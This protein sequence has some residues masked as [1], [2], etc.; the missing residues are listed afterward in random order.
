M[1]EPT[2]ALLMVARDW[3]QRRELVTPWVF[4]PGSLKRA[5][6]HTD[7]YTPQSLWAAL[8]R[9]EKRAGIEHHP[10]RASHELR[11]LLAGEV[12]ELTGNAKLAMDAI[13]DRDIRQAQRYLRPRQDALK[14][15]FDR[16]DSQLRSKRQAK[17]PATGTG[18]LQTLTDNDL[19]SAPPGSRTQNLR[20]KS[21][22]LCQLS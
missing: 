4:P 15:A 17:S 12:N 22:L 13:G 11:R 16:L 18:L 10:R 5:K 2:R 6:V 14:A 3:H 9:A 8:R 1:R 21:P 19:H 7:I 20:I